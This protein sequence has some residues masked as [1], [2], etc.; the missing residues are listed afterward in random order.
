MGLTGSTCKGE[1][2]RLL[3]MVN[4]QEENPMV[5]VLMLCLWWRDPKGSS[6]LSFLHL[7]DTIP[8]PP[9]ML[10]HPHL[11]VEHIRKILLYL[12]ELHNLMLVKREPL[13]SS[14]TWGEWG[15]REGRRKKELYET[16]S[17]EEAF[18]KTSLRQAGIYIEIS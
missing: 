8:D 13:E 9:V 10:H 6:F 5:G 17:I 2:K 4:D 15:W 16:T 14:T 11:L 18:I 7:P 1:C 3:C 12:V